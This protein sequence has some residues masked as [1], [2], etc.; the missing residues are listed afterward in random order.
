MLTK[1]GC[2][3]PQLTRTDATNIVKANS[4]YFM[5]VSLVFLDRNG[6]FEV[7]P[8]LTEIISSS[9]SM[10]SLQEDR[11]TSPEFDPAKIAN[12]ARVLL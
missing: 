11:S 9:K 12:K 6:S 2:P 3:A 1:L 7:A 10:E 4:K 8:T 5:G